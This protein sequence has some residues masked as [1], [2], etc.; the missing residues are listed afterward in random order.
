MTVINPLEKE[1]NLHL[2][3]PIK[4]IG[5]KLRAVIVFKRAQKTGVLFQR[6]VNALAIFDDIIVRSSR[7]AWTTGS[8]KPLLRTTPDS[9]QRLLHRP[10]DGIKQSASWRAKRPADFRASRFNWKILALDVDDNRTFKVFNVNST[11]S[12]GKRTTTVWRKNDISRNRGARTSL[13]WL[14][15]LVE[16]HWRLCQ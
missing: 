4:Q 9:H 12:G 15:L 10:Q 16:S 13:I 1:R 8:S 2:P 5:V 7:S 6:I 3:Y 14:L 11:T